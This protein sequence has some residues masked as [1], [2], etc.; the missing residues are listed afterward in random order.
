M[1]MDIGLCEGQ[2]KVVELNCFNGSAFYHC[3]L[4]KIIR[5]VSRYQE[6]SVIP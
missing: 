2:F 6:L 1:V 5:Y 3:D 4:P